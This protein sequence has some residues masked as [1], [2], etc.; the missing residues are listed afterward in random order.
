MDRMAKIAPKHPHFLSL[1]GSRWDNSAHINPII[2]VNSTLIRKVHPKPILRW[3]PTNPTMTDNKQLPQI[4][5][6]T[7]NA[8]IF[9]KYIFC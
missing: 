3:L 1:S 5:Y 9:F 8:G 4:P 6:I 7:T 2:G